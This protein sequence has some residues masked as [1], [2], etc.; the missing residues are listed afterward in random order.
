MFAS[1][2]VGKKILVADDNSE[3]RRLLVLH[4]GR[5]GYQTVE[6]STG[7]GAVDQ[8]RTTLPDLIIMDLAM[9]D[10]SGDEAIASLKADTLTRAIP[11]VVLT[12]FTG[13]VL[14]DRAIA[15]GATEVVHKPV[16]FEYLNVVLRRHLSAQQARQIVR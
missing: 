12:A 6:A 4:L 13:G 8:A 2:S 11:V 7:H 3:I 14:V 1:A 16:T 10:G 5:S 15:A 9:P